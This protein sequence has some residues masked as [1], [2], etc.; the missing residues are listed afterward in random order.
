MDLELPLRIPSLLCGTH[1]CFQCSIILIPINMTWMVRMMM[2]MRMRRFILT[3]LVCWQQ[4]LLLALNISR[5]LQA[6][7]RTPCPTHKYTNRETQ[8]HK[9][10]HTNTQI[11]P[12]RDV[13]YRL[14][15]SMSEPQMQIQRDENWG[16]GDANTHK[17]VNTN[18]FDWILATEQITSDMLWSSC[19]Y[20]QIMLSCDPVT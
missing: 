17:H 14:V 10:A 12:T 11:R 18:M 5:D 1:K 16:M 8:T 6:R 20:D 19:Q 15:Y 7:V 9:Y 2:R 3:E 4:R 13:I